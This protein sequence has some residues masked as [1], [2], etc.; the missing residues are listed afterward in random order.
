MKNNLSLSVWIALIILFFNSCSGESEKYVIGIS[1]CSQ[2]EW[3]EKQNAEM[4]QESRFYP[5]LELKVLSA[6]DDNERQIRDIQ[7]LIDQKV[8]LLI[9]SPNEGKAITPIVEKAYDAGIP[10]IVIDR[11]VM[12]D[13]YT[14]FIGADNIQIGEAMG[15][16][17]QSLGNEPLRLFEVCGLE[18]STSAQERTQGLY[19]VIGRLNHIERMGSIDASWRMEDAEHKMDSVFKL[20]PDINFIVAQNDR[21]AI[22]A[23]KA[24]KR[25]R[26]EKGIRFIG[27][28]ALTNKDFGVDQ[29]MQGNMAATFIYPTGG[30]VVIQTAMHILNGEPFERD[31][32]LSS[33]QV[34]LTN[35]RIMMLQD[36]LVKQSSERVNQLSE[37]L[38]SFLQRRNVQDILVASFIVIIVLLFILC[39]F[40]LHAYW[41]NKRH[42]TEL[43]KQNAEIVAQR[44]Q[45]ITLSTELEKAT[46]AKLSFFTNVSHEFRTPL[47][48]IADPVNQLLNSKHLDDNEHMLLNIVHKNTIILLRLVN[49]IL[50]FRKFESGKLKVN[51]SEFNIWNRLK[52]STSAFQSLAMRK[53]VKFILKCD[54][55][56][57]YDMI[58]D[59]EKIDR[60]VYNLLSNS[61][62]FTP[63]GGEVKI[64]LSNAEKTD[65]PY[66]QMVVS[67]TG[68]GISAEHIEHIFDDFYQVDV[69]HSGSGIGLALV[70]AF[71]EL[72]HGNIAIDSQEG[73]GTSFIVQLPLKLAGTLEEGLQQNAKMQNLKEGAVFDA[74]QNIFDMTYKAEEEQE[75]P[76]V[77]VIDDNQDVRDYLKSLLD[78]EYIIVEASN[79]KEGLEQ[80]LKHTPNAIICDVMMPIMDGMECCKRLKSELET[81]HIPIMMLTAYTMDEQRLK[82]YEC[83]ADSYVS[84]PFSANM[85]KTRLKNL[86]ENRKRVASFFESEKEISKS[87]LGKVDQGFVQRLKQLIDKNMKNSEYSVED[88]GRDMNLSRV[89]LYRKVKS[90]TD[91]SPNE[92][93]RF[94]RLKRA[95]QL[96]ATTEKSVSE[97]AYEVGFNTPAYFTKCYKDYYGETPTHNSH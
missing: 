21:M 15:E 83:G 35:A 12:S 90:L 43:S 86:L 97:I 36:A 50:D 4:E 38:D 10:I 53:H 5:N 41:L 11:K 79:G 31:V 75:K 14:A 17:I 49:Q 84:K 59:G 32:T 82:G 58:S 71:V 51:L 81:S 45:L 52:D 25:H 72:L 68:I 28:D 23:F 65:I 76:I 8:D 85:L 13:K 57:I 29:V 56:G 47:T 60:I 19:N 22:G 40:I 6:K 42:N 67:D 55:H 9:V 87:T 62:K 16:Y 78:R 48:L 27:V 88:L 1:Q 37:Q 73:V 92:L 94:T 69:H 89:Q 64:I 30:D 26:L 20:H 74:E 39:F 24:A 91:Y 44:D 18:G 96:L 2:D 95:K 54:E 77:L 61:F 63:E 66:L 80:A 7:Q 46:H 34:D 93:L 3:R 33:A 70:K